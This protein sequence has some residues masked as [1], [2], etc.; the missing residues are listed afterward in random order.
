MIGLP[1]V[2]IGAAL[3]LLLGLA[4]VILGLGMRRRRGL[5]AGKT[6]A[7]DNLTLTSRRYGLMTRPDRLVK[8][9]GEVIP[10][11]WKSAR[12]PRPWH[13]AQLGVDFLVVEDQLR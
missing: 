10:E 12:A 13:V 1:W 6:V 8:S 11:E 4:L 9:G 3:A 2:A 5:G 7:L